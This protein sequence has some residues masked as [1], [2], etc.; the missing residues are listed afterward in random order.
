MNDIT[1]NC[2]GVA[3]AW[4]AYL[5]LHSAM[6]SITVTDFLKRV[7]GD[8]YR[9]Y[10]LFFNIVAII[11]LVPLVIY[12][13]YVKGEMFFTWDGYLAIL[14]WAIFAGG[15]LLFWAGSRHYSFSS[16]L[17]LRQIREGSRHNLMNRSGRLDS[18][19]ILGVIRHPYYAGVI[20]LF[21]SAD[22]DATKLVTNIVVTVYVIIGTLLEERKLLLEF[23]DR[24]REYSEKV[25]MLFPVKWL[26]LKVGGRIVRKPGELIPE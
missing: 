6:I 7:L 13:A 21:W 22:L 9:Y 3:L 16:F 19:G 14:K 18:T 25:S 24:Y 12:S 10:R 20:L 8:G 17:G 4:S 26:K 15:I 11:T 1:I 2:I 5:A 23:G